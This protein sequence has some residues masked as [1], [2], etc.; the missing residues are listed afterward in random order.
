MKNVDDIY[1]LSPLQA[2]ILFHCLAA[3]SDAMYVEQ[4][5]AQLDGELVTAQLQRAWQSVVA[6]HPALRTAFVWEGLKEPLQVVRRQVFVPWHALDWSDR[7]VE[8]HAEA[9]EQLLAADRSRPFVLTRPPLMRL[10]IVRLAPDRHALL[11]TFHHLLL[12][13]WS[14]AIVQRDV[15]E[16]YAFE[17]AGV[18]VPVEAPRPY[19][20]FIRWLGHQDLGRA[21][22][23]W[24]ARLEGA[25]PTPL[26]F[27]PPADAA[28]E[29]DDT[30][31]IELA[32]SSEATASVMHAA[33]TQGLALNTVCQAAWALVLARYAT[34][35]DVLFGATVSGRPPALDGVDRMVGLFI[36]ALC[37]RVTMPRR[38]RV[39]AWL[40]RPQ[41]ESAEARE[42]EYSPLADVQRWSGR[43]PGALF[44]TLL[45]YENYPRG[46]G[47]FDAPIAVP[48]RV[49]PLRTVEK[50]NYP[51][52]LLVNPGDRLQL[53]LVVHRRRFA[54]DAM[55][56]VLA[57]V[58]V[59]IEA[60]L[61]D[62]ARELQAVSLLTPDDRARVVGDWNDTTLDPHAFGAVHESFERQAT[63]TPDALA[64]VFGDE[65]ATYDALNRRANRL[66]RHIR[67]QGI[68]P[69]AIVG[70]CL[71]RSIDLV[72]AVL[73][74]LKAGAAYAPL[75]P[76][77]PE[78]RLASVLEDADI[79]LV[80]THTSLA[81]RL[82]LA[83]HLLCLV[84]RW[85]DPSTID[86]EGNIAMDVAPESLAYVIF[87]S[88]STGRP[89]GVMIPHRALANHMRWMQ[90]VYPL[91]AAD[92]VLQKTPFGFDASVWEFH[93]PLL[94]GATL[95]VAQ[96]GAHQDPASLVEAV[97]R[98]AISIL[99]VVPSMLRLLV[100]TDGFGRCGS[101]RRVFVGGEPLASDLQTRFFEVSTVELVNLYGPTEVTIDSV[102]WSC[103][104]EQSH[105]QVPIG[106]PVDNTTAYVL[107]ERLELAPVTLAGELWLGGVQVGRGYCR[108]P[109]LTAER[110]LPDPFS[111]APGAR[112]YRTGD[113]ARYRAD[114]VCEF[115]GRA[116]HQVKLHGYRIE[117]GEIETALRAQPG[118]QDALVQL[119]DDTPG[120]PPQLVAYVVSEDAEPVSTDSVL[121][122]LRA[123]LPEYMV[124]AAVVSLDALPLTPNGK[125]DRAALP[126]PGAFRRSPDSYIPPR[127]A[128]ELQLVRLWE[129]LLNTHPI[130]VRDEFFAIGGHSI[131]VL[132]LV[133]HIER[134]F[135]IRVSL[136]DLV[137]GTTIERLASMIRQKR[138]GAEPRLVLLQPDGAGIPLFGI[139]PAGG[140]LAC[141]LPLAEVLGRDRPFYALQPRS[142]ME[143]AGP[144]RT[145]ELMAQA[146]L[147][148]L[149]RAQASGPYALIGWSMGGLVAYELA[150]LLRDAGER[151][152]LVALLDVRVPDPDQPPQD[153]TALAVEMGLQI[154]NLDARELGD[155]QGDQ[156]LE[157]LLE[158]AR[159]QGKLAH[160]VDMRWVRWLAD[161]FRLSVEATQQY[162]P[163]PYDGS[164]LLVRA[165][166]HE[167]P[168]DDTL[169]W[170]ALARGGVEVRWVTGAHYNIVQQPHVAAVADLLRASLAADGRPSPLAD[171]VVDIA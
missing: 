158:L 154:L 55:S 68:G 113:V 17:Y 115:L 151:V 114:G 145:I 150:C 74:V 6:R 65:T 14:C 34:V 1:P 95:V 15:A 18:S 37:V 157:A 104:R 46:G 101:L 163:R 94:A 36:N 103:R 52:T 96:P 86:D 43:G 54:A 161:G 93:A 40:A 128:L 138:A 98:H 164:L 7:P 20:D 13:G 67:A 120:P 58:A 149:R 19:A 53:A 22:Q 70:I 85:D 121:Q 141:Y 8:D 110:F 62:P 170:G 124:P 89:K 38:E 78:A 126:P 21:E 81:G 4:Y 73:A 109:D 64:V 25:E 80:L 156:R 48:L 84:D 29:P 12:D 31:Q 30:A 102:A 171:T 72:V 136:A 112:L 91:S 82:P 144:A 44:E 26:R 117:L 159:Q 71:E 11:W 10:T 153:A 169:G 116:D 166:E 162:R 108:R 122:A 118:V 88:G 39:G 155:A 76:Q 27:E 140:T 83:P 90:R 142:S 152:D 79:S 9:L 16:C 35:D 123:V 105:G 3:T 132:H 63:R 137:Q 60:L 143:E 33:R 24:R 23:F 130:G 50:T 99:Q 51:V 100:D 168:G 2:G 41:V 119:R 106:V 107:D 49:T 148:E 5:L 69:E 129:E 135:E 61:E 56:R 147:E 127:E 133:A 87:T 160:E 66:A 45:V 28:R 146:D 77:Y 75:D 47:S 165:A 111:D 92:R 59:A 125:V 57:H 167:V 32:L 97:D 131:L 139:V 134:T 42:H